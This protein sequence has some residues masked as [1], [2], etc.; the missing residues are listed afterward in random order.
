MALLLNSPTAQA[1][2][3]ADSSDCSQILRAV[4]NP[5]NHPEKEFF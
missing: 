4:K 5:L 2:L 3:T 1:Q